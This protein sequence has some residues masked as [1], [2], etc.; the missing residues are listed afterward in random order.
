MSLD[1][2]AIPGVGPSL[3]DALAAAKIGSVKKLAK[4]RLE[5]LVAVPGIGETT[6][7]R[8][9]EAASALHASNKAGNKSKKKRKKREKKKSGKQ[10][11]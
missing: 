10:K 3:A 4:I 2:T 7:R 5:K 1:L 11:K 8:M 9:I 6:G